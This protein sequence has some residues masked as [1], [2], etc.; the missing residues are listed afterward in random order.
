[1]IYFKKGNEIFEYKN[2][3]ELYNEV[4]FYNI[5]KVGIIHSYKKTIRHYGQLGLTY[6]NRLNRFT[7]EHNLLLKDDKIDFKFTNYS[8]FDD[9]G[10]YY[11]VLDIM[12]NT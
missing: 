11:S 2:K 3:K 6:Y 5:L 9:K 8:I 1:M 7:K 10:F 12:K 4:K